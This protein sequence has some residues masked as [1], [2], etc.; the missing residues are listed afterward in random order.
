MRE[1]N[2]EGLELLAAQ[3]R[4]QM[5]ESFH[6]GVVAV[7]DPDGNLIFSKGDAFALI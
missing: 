3:E 2:A 4:G 6:H 1:L 7:V 5:L